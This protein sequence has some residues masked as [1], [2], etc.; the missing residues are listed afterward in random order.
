MDIDSKVDSLLKSKNKKKINKS[1]YFLI[2]LVVIFTIVALNFILFYNKEDD[3]LEDVQPV[4]KNLLDMKSEEWN[5]NGSVY[6]YWEA[7]SS[8]FGIK[9]L[10]TLNVS[11]FQGFYNHYTHTGLNASFNNETWYDANV[12]LTTVVNWSNE[13]NSYKISWIINT[14]EAPNDMYYRLTFAIDKRCVNFINGTIG[15]HS[16]TF[17][18]PNLGS[19]NATLNISFNWSDV[20]PLIQNN[21]VFVKRGTK[22]IGNN[23]YFWF[24]VQTKHTIQPEQVFVID[25]IFGDNTQDANTFGLSDDTAFTNFTNTAGE[26]YADN[27]TVC[28]RN[29]VNGEIIQC[30]VYWASNNSQVNNGLTDTQN[31]DEE[32]ALSWHTLDFSDPKPYIHNN[33]A[34]H[35]CIGGTADNIALQIAAAGGDSAWDKNCNLGGMSWAD[36]IPEDATQTH[37]I[38]IYCSYTESSGNNAPTLSGEIPANQSTDK[39]LTPVCNVTANDADGGDTLTVYWYEN[40]TG[41]WVLQQTNSSVSPGTSV[42]WDDYSNASDYSTTYWWSVNVSDGTDWVNETYHFTTR[43]RILK[44][45]FSG[46]LTGGNNTATELLFDGW[47][48]GGNESS[49]NELFQGYLTGGNNSSVES[50]FSGYL[51]GGNITTVDLLFEGWLTGGN[52]TPAEGKTV[53]E[54]F[55]GWLTGG[56]ETVTLQTLFSGY[57]T[58]GNESS[59][60]E[61]FQGYLTGGNNTATALL[62]EGWLTGGNTTYIKSVKELFSGY[63]TGGNV[64]PAKELFSGWLTGGNTSVIPITITL[65]YPNN[66]SNITKLQPTV[67]FNLSAA[68]GTVMNYTIYIHNTTLLF[69][70]NNVNNGTQ[71]DADHLYYDATEYYNQYYWSVNVESGGQWINETFNFKIIKESAGFIPSDYTIPLVIAAAALMLAIIAFRFTLKKKKTY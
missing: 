5:E 67:F 1:I 58:G 41:S 39:G 65:E 16:V 53:K 32:G 64:S 68:S 55:S 4:D 37:I 34:Y 71:F 7:P 42:Q 38:N 2:S 24:R 14:S 60:N 54:L 62:F 52:T 57:L 59:V 28:L 45:L 33:T 51:T 15:N 19:D 69:S 23:S 48:T 31:V 56:N 29:R 13:T 8:S 27:M 12:G 36:P 25:P 10:T 66:Q 3:M 26:G 6:D 22:T 40:T 30:A 35:L 20:I 11:W 61:L 44:L 43:N 63:L 9:N 21:H 18:I 70:K 50:L 49:V 17:E 46:Y 47:I